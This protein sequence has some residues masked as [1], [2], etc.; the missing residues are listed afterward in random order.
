[1]KLFYVTRQVKY[2]GITITFQK[3]R[4]KIALFLAAIEGIEQLF[5]VLL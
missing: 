1:M 4:G 3:H 2:F 5:L